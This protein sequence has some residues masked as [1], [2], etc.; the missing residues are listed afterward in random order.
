[1]AQTFLFFS[2]FEKTETQAD[3]QAGKQPSQD[4]SLGK[5]DDDFTMIVRT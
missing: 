3:R 4:G 2:L 1:M 5:A